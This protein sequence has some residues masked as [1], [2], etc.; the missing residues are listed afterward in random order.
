MICQGQ[1][2]LAYSSISSSAISLFC[3]YLTYED[4]A[5]RHTPPS[6]FFCKII[7]WQLGPGVQMLI[8]HTPPSFFLLQNYF[9]ATWGGGEI[10]ANEW[11]S[12]TGLTSMAKAMNMTTCDFINVA[13]V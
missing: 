13:L 9:F 3:I 4:R 7:I 12:K 2:S 6:F 11:E 8:W 5:L 10:C 1:G